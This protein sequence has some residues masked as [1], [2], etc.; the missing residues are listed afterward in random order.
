MRLPGSEKLK[1]I[2]IVEQSHLPARRTL[3]ILGIRPSTFDR[4]YERHRAGGS[5]ALEDKP[6]RLDAALQRSAPTSVQPPV[7]PPARSI[8]LV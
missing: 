7:V 8:F 4:W 3:E 1:I 6:S 5:E 2:R